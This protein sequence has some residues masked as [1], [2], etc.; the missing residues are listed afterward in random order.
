LRGIER[1][2]ERTAAGETWF[3]KVEADDG[4]ATT[5]PKAEYDAQGLSPDFW[6]LLKQR[7]SYSNVVS[8]GMKRVSADF[9]S[10][11]APLGF[12]KAGARRWARTR[13]DR[14]DEL[15][16]ER[17]GSSYGAPINASVDLRIWLS[18]RHANT[19]IADGMSVRCDKVRRPDGHAYHHRF[20]AET[21]STYDQCLDDLNL[22]VTEFAEAWFDENLPSHQRLGTE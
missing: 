8:E 9:S 22:F 10:R 20:N 1:W 11:I 7:R 18:V 4:S 5:L 15:R 16:I 13:G 12:K 6:S 17:A 21:F 19:T 3:A 2:A 14:T